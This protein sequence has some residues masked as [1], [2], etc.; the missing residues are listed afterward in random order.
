MN[1]YQVTF[2]N[3]RV[4]MIAATSSSAALTRAF[5]LYQ[6]QNAG[7]EADTETAFRSLAWQGSIDVPIA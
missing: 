5:A 6:Q 2:I 7:T 3:S 1:A 4:F